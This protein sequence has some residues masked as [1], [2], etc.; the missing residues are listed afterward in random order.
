M[1]RKYVSIVLTTLLLLS[2]ATTVFAD[3]PEPINPVEPVRQGKPIP[4]GHTTAPDGHEIPIYLFPED[5]CLTQAAL[6]VGAITKEQVAVSRAL[7]RDLVIAARGAPSEGHPWCPWG[8]T[9]ATL[10][11]KGWDDDNDYYKDYEHPVGW[12][13]DFVCVTP[14]YWA[15]TGGNGPAHEYHNDYKPGIA[16]HRLKIGL[17]GFP[18]WFASLQA[19]MRW[20]H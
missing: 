13:D 16:R 6:D 5:V 19:Y 17:T 11:S 12:N 9:G 3:A 1:T 14:F 2:V 8:G 18:G 4:I 15:R 7:A 10:I 20:A